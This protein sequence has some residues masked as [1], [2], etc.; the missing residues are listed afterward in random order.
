MSLV[1]FLRTQ[2]LE[3]AHAHKEE[4]KLCLNVNSMYN[5]PR[6]YYS[7][8]Y[9]PESD[10]LLLEGYSKQSKTPVQEVFQIFQDG[11][12][13][14]LGELLMNLFPLTNDP[15]DIC[16]QGQEAHRDTYLQQP[17]HTMEITVWICN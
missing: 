5:K 13:I 11:K 10:Q 1:P 14:R 12:N 2:F 3:F 15:T 8:Y 16:I 9:N 6:Y 4:V 7:V 17:V